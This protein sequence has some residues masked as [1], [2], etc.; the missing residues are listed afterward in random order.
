MAEHTISGGITAGDWDSGL[1]MSPPKRTRLG[2]RVVVVGNHKGGTGKSTV[3]MHVMVALLKSGRSV[4]LIDLDLEQQTLT[5]F[6][7]NRRE[8]AQQSSVA[9]E[10]PRHVPI[11]EPDWSGTEGGDAQVVA[12]FI[13]ALSDLGD[14]DVIVIDTP[15]SPNQ[16][17]LLAH[18][19]ADTL[20][21][22]INDSFVDL[23]LIVMV[24]RAGGP[25][26]QASRYAKAVAA[27]LEG[28]RNA[29]G[30]S[31]DW[32][33]VRNR[34]SSVKA[35]SQIGVSEALA[36][37]APQLGFRVVA[38]L[39]ERPIFR[40]L[41]PFGLTAFDEAEGVPGKRPK[42]SQLLARIEVR[43]LIDALGLVAPRSEP[44][45]HAEVPGTFVDSWLLASEPP[46]F[47]AQAMEP[48]GTPGANGF[49]GQ[50]QGA[51]AAVAS[52]PGGG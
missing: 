6:L 9:V 51:P 39:T 8:W 14:C 46:E 29:C 25:A 18:G 43:E 36:V 37:I 52:P 17:N 22:P 31:S 13:R 38:G 48:G 1:S 44:E 49:P 34:I 30:R 50:D 47:A 20:L 28:R 27:A 41:F 26:P 3:A 33:V 42:T 15:G 32:V 23:D 40:H 4:G 10:L 12:R 5:R 24:G 7:D 35:R 21:T 45:E 16:L 19:M 11:V 2:P